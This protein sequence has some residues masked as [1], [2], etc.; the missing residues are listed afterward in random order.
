MNTALK[1]ALASY[2]RA[3]LVAVIT[4]TAMGK[5]DPRDLLMAAIVAVAAPLLRALNPKDSAFGVVADKATVEIVKL[6]KADAKT[7]TTK[8]SAAKG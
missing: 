6:L 7:K 8:K 4:A 5:T 1:A 2:G 3:A